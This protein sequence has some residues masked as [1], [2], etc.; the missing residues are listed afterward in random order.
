MPSNSTPTDA[1]EFPLTS[2]KPCAVL[3]TNVVLDWLLFD[4]PAVAPLAA[5][6]VTGR[7]RWVASAAMRDELCHVLARGLA[8]T[9]AADTTALLAIWDAH[10]ALQPDPPPQPLRCSD[11]EDQKFIDLALAVGARWL[12]SRDRAL[13][14]LARRAAPSGLTILSPSQW[15]L[16]A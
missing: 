9:L 10:A 2:Q 4:D 12:V 15:R 1:G 5:A 14:K 16:A 8:D 11:L 6:V 3:D 13:L 7:A